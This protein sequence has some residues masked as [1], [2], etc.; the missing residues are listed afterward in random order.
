MSVPGLRSPY[1]TVDGVVYFGRMIDKMRLHAAGD[2]PADY[3]PFLGGAN[4]YSFDGRCCRFLRIDY[5]AL[6]AEALQGGT[7]EE[8]LKWACSRGRTPSETEIEVWNGFMQK[9]GWCD[10]ASGALQREAKKSGITDRSV[11]T[12]FDLHDAE[13]DRPPRFPHD[14]SPTVVSPDQVTIIPGLRSPR[15][16]IGGI[17][18]FGRML[19]RIRLFHQGR[20]PGPW[21]AAKGAGLGFDVTCCRFLHVNHAAL[22]EETLK[23][24]GDDEL[25]EWATEVGRKPSDEEIEIWNAYLSKRCWRD[26]FTDRLHVR[27]AEVGMRPGSV[28]TMFDFIDLDEGRTLGESQKS[29]V[30]R[31]K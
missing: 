9:R 18:H 7:M 11:A 8:L 17:Y 15:E 6:A 20:L 19:D 13:E 10:S 28:Y 27:L 24:R 22:E 21:A 4:P 1:D 12:F 3:H 25:F 26:Q 16:K 14:P 5:D 30:K 2:L 29:E 23:G 31:Q